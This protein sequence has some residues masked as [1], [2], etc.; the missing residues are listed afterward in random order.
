MPIPTSAPPVN[1]KSREFYMPG[2]E[3]P[4]PK[5]LSHGRHPTCPEMSVTVIFTLETRKRSQLLPRGGTTTKPRSELGACVINPPCHAARG[6]F[7]CPRAPWHSVWSL[8]PWPL[9]PSPA[10]WLRSLYLL[11]PLL[12]GGPGHLTSARGPGHPSL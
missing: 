2:S 10:F 3:L 11:L 9:V 8:E 4:A 12:E 7:P 1:F 5:A 6:R